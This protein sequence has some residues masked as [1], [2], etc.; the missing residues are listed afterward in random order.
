MIR[1][2][3]LDNQDW[4]NR[5]A[6]EPDFDLVGNVSDCQAVLEQVEALRPDLVLLN[7]ATSNLERTEVAQVIETT[8]PVLILGKD[9]YLE[10]ALAFLEAGAKGYL[11]KGTSIEEIKETVRLITQVEPD[12]DPVPVAKRCLDLEPKSPSSSKSL[13]LLGAALIVGFFALESM[14][15]RN[16]LSSPVAS[17]Q[18]IQAS[19]SVSP[20]RSRP[21]EP[22]NSYQVMRTYPGKIDSRRTS[23]LGFE[24]AG[25][26][27]TVSVDE[28]GR[29]AAGAPI[30]TL[31]TSQLK[32]QEQNLLAQRAEAMAQLRAMQAGPRSEA[33]AVAQAAVQD[34]REQLDLARKKRD[35]RE[36]LYSEGAISREQLDEAASE[37]SVLQARLEAAQ[38]ELEELKAGTRRETIEAQQ[39]VLAQL[40]AKLAS[41][42]VERQQSVLKAP[43]AGI[44][45]SRLVDEGTV[46]SVGQP[47]LRLVEPALEARVD[48]P[49]AAA[50][51]LQPG[52]TQQLFIGEN[53]YPARITTIL[54]EVNTATQTATVVLRMGDAVDRG[55]PG[56]KVRLEL[57]ETIPTSGYWLPTSALLRGSRGLWSCYVLV[58][59]TATS[60]NVYQAERQ[61]VEIIHSQSDRVLVRGT[62]QSGDRVVLSGTHRLVDGQLVRPL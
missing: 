40:D 1:I 5:L 28:G 29:V 21:L 16:W 15:G 55:L 25:Q 60:P 27:V 45:A 53:R 23:Q 17:R 9:S 24:R 3:L 62:L 58:P 12:E 37:T 51:Q 10:S 32:A 2:L 54:P 26:I 35:R 57:A 50:N 22:V 13:V 56:Q 31:D 34:A 14:I 44:V 43:F 49:V 8:H 52:S 47:V 42:A 41:L 4:L 30:A 33:I 6:L 36:A 59:A 20:V 46:V 39:A 7:L 48:V 11:P 19:D 61:D 18:S 38:S